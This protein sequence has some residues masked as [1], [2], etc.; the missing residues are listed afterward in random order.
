M[1]PKRLAIVMA[2]LG[3][4]TWL[5]AGNTGRSQDGGQA[6]GG[7]QD[8]MDVLTQGPIH[9]AFAEPVE[10]KPAPT[11][12]VPKQPPEPID[13]A[14][15]DQ[16][17]SG[18]AQWIS[19]YWA[20]DDDRGDFIWV[21]GIWRVSP[22]G[23][24]WMPGYWN[25]VEDGWQWTP[26]Y[27]AA[28][29]QADVQYLPPPPDPLEAAPSTPR[30]N[31]DSVMIPGSWYYATDRY[32]WR[33]A[34]WVDYRPG[35]VWV[36]AHFV[37]TP[38][39]F[40][41][42]DGYW[43][44]EL[45]R[46]GM[47]FSPIHF[48]RPLWQQ[49]GWVYRPYYPIYDNFLMGCMFIRPG[50]YHYYYGDF[51]DARYRGLGFTAFIDFRF[52]R[53]GYD[54]LF[55]YYRW[56]NRHDPRW[57]AEL[58][59]VY[60]GRYSGEFPRPPRT[61]VQQ[62]QIIQNITVNNRTTINN[63]N[64]TNFVTASVPLNRFQS[65]QV[66]L[67]RVPSA[68]LAE[69]K[70]YTQELRT[71][72]KERTRVEQQLV[73]RGAAPVTT[74]AAPQTVA[75]TLPKSPVVTTAKTYQPPPH[76]SGAV[77][78]RLTGEAERRTR[79]EN[80]GRVPTETRTERRETATKPA[81]RVEPKPKTEA[82]TR[83][84]PKPETKPTPKLPPR[85]EEKKDRTT[86]PTERRELE[87]RPPTQQVPERHIENP[88]PRRVDQPPPRRTENPPPKQAPKDKDKNPKDK[89]KKQ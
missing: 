5:A 62:Q 60:A 6:R 82:E 1:F 8:G 63:I 59:S 67:T 37:W 50:Y 11:K 18:D 2:M 75:L 28:A 71:A 29:E 70:R 89:D 77:K 38:A 64:V 19:G 48:S 54:P 32:V 30:P 20:W 3:L 68:Q 78:P 85:T 22:P 10:F 58:R 17:P 52:G 45:V 51:F 33:P 4:F 25:Q 83:I 47:C 74:R 27:W 41:F 31:A 43:D 56:H 21:S 65:K 24:Q 39:G 42:V 13:E 80:S 72:S 40:V 57:F 61:I 23:R 35:W 49:A 76:P 53:F 84:K 46:R 44:L 55:S 16:K 87:K 36:P 69:A 34:Y 15:P 9:E 12:V 14:P 79:T 88:P 81:P 73:S 86:V 7:E 26:G 66:T